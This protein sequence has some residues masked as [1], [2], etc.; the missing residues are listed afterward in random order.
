MS[1]L[2]AAARTAWLG[3]LMLLLGLMPFIHGH[4]G[5]PVQ[6][7][8]HIHA[9]S[10]AAEVRASPQFS[11]LACVAEDHRHAA[12]P[13]GP[14]LQHP[15]PSDVEPAPGIVT[16]R[17]SQLRAAQPDSA[18]DAAAAV[19]AVARAALSLPFADWRAARVRPQ[20]HELLPRSRHGL[21]PPGQAPP[22][23]HLA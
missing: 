19:P 12:Q 21:P 1:A 3:L 17:L 23:S 2:A 4:L 15:E 22:L 20:S 18:G 9:L 6:N 13:S 5:Q 14:L 10:A 16:T 8:W 11:G 7:G